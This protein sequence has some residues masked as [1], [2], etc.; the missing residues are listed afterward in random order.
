MQQYN[1][2]EKKCFRNSGPEIIAPQA[3]R[4]SIFKLI[5]MR[6]RFVVT[7]GGLAFSALQTL[8]TRLK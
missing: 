8:R 5:R 3:S 1:T 6:D 7:G 4:R 2:I